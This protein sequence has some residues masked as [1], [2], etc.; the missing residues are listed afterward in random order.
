MTT[1]SPPPPP[2]ASSPASA[3]RNQAMQQA[4][5]HQ[6][7]LT[8][9]LGALGVLETLA[10]WLAGWQETVKP[11]I[12]K[13]V[14]VVFA[15]N[16]GIAQQGVS[17]YPA[18]VTAQM[19]QNFQAGG[20]AINQL[21]ALGNIG[22]EVI[23]LDLDRPT[24]DFSQEPA[25]DDEEFEQAMNLGINV[26]KQLRTSGVDCLL[27]GEMGIGNTTSAAAI[28][29]AL[30]GGQA[31]DWAGRGTGVDDHALEAKTALIAQ[32]VEKHQLD[33]KDG[34]AILRTFGGRELAAIAGVVMQARL[35]KLPVILDGFVVS[36]AAAPLFAL[37]P[38]SLE[39]C[40]I[41][42]VS[43]EQGHKKLADALNKQPILNLNMRLGE[44]SGAAIALYILKA[45]L[46]THN[47]MASFAD[48][49]VSTSNG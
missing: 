7:Q 13:P 39:H 47:G 36:A 40:I 16:H 12:N 8:K 25:M 32:A 17:A 5:L 3:V 42:H 2:P 11:V 27:L 22:L 6:S 4:A 18:E 19:V 20:A 37:H 41:A 21:C 35:E 28:C 34:L 1:T 24:K 14:C 49:G 33:P 31:A 30:F 23:P 45:A 38:D 15:G 9:P 48:A 43:A 44:G 26:C 46:A 10:V 29:H